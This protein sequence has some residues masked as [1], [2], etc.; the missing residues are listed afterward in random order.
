MGACAVSFFG[1]DPFLKIIH[2]NDFHE[3]K[4]LIE[5]LNENRSGTAFLNFHG[6]INQEIFL[7]IYEAIPDSLKYAYLLIKDREGNTIVSDSE[8]M[9][10]DKQANFVKSLYIPLNAKEGDRE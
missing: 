5:G 8:T 10:V 4:N 7:R 2:R 1:H 9:A 6:E 3:I